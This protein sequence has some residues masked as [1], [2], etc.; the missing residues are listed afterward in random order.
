MI[1]VKSKLFDNHVPLPL[2]CNRSWILWILE[3]LVRVVGDGEGKRESVGEGKGN[4]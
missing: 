2:N 1:K 3:P 4:K